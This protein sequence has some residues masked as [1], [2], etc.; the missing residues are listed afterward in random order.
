MRHIYIKYGKENKAGQ[1]STFKNHVF[2]DRFLPECMLIV[3]LLS[4]S[5]IHTHPRSLFDLNSSRKNTRTEMYKQSIFRTQS[6]ICQL[7]IRELH[8]VFNSPFNTLDTFYSA[9]L[10]LC[11]PTGNFRHWLL[12]SLAHCRLRKLSHLSLWEFLR[13]W[14]SWKIW[15]S[16]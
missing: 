13:V 4:H 14:Y 5:L 15:K 1:K 2:S 10:K 6:T 8:Y 11:I 9:S 7:T 12:T 16:R 3:P